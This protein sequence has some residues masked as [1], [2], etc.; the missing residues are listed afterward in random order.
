[1]GLTEIFGKGFNFATRGERERLKA[2]ET[3]VQA[4]V[5][6]SVHVISSSDYLIKADPNTSTAELW[7]AARAAELAKEGILDE[8]IA[9]EIARTDIDPVLK[10]PALV[11]TE[12][13][14]DHAAAPLKPYRE[15]KPGQMV[16]A[17]DFA[18][19]AM[20]W[21]VFQVG[22]FMLAASIANTRCTTGIQK[23]DDPWT[24]KVVTHFATDPS[25]LTLLN[26]QIELGANRRNGPPDQYYSQLGREW[27]RD[28]YGIMYPVAFKQMSA[29]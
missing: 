2:R 1:M 20:Q 22:D 10:T 25:G 12:A 11:A 4:P 6:E 28:A 23:V 29:I 14:I 17:H 18:L 7:A 3:V 21:G 5:T 26:Q 19:I 13:V 8:V 9:Q 15:F 24:K 27:A 16:D